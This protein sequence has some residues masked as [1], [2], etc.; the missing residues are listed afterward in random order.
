MMK[1]HEKLKDSDLLKQLNLLN[2]MLREK[3]LYMI[4]QKIKIEEDGTIPFT[5]LPFF[6]SEKGDIVEDTELRNGIERLKSWVSVWD[7]TIEAFHVDMANKG[8]KGRI[9]SVKFPE[10]EH[11]IESI[12]KLLEINALVG[13]SDVPI[14]GGEAR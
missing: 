13:I 10:V 2:H 7:L 3:C 14:R 4:E 1:K 9:A 8:Q 11:T 5:E 6:L 12:R